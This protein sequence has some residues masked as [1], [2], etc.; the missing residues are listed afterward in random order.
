ML[1]THQ[2]FIQLVTMVEG[3]LV[4][5]DAPGPASTVNLASSDFHMLGIFSLPRMV[6]KNLTSLGM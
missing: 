4:V 5:P 6:E 1:T 2:G 3:P